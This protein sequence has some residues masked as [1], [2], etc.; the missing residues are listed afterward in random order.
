MANQ[1]FANLGDVWKHLWLTGVI[2]GSRPSQYVETHAESA[3]YRLVDDSERSLGVRTF[4]AVCGENDLL[5]SGPADAYVA[6]FN[7]MTAGTD[8]RVPVEP[9]FATSA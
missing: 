5:R 8:L 1:H 4:L 7:D 2:G 3:L 6:A 9:V